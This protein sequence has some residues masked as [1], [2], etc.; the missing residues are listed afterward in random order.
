MDLFKKPSSKKRE[1][2]QLTPDLLSPKKEE[3]VETDRERGLEKGREKIERL[4]ERGSEQI[5]T[6][7]EDKPGLKPP[8]AKPS[9]TPA[10][11][12]V[13]LQKIENILQ[14]DLEKLYFDMD[15]AHRRLFKEEGERA[16][17]KIEKFLISCKSVAIKVL[18]IIK[19]WL[20]LIPGINK[21]FIEQEAK[22]KTDKIIKINR[23]D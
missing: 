7:R 16:A 14:E 21:F 3:E 12:S 5:Q 22:I 19:N 11:K 10:A 1:A 6:F 20:R 4:K 15:E 9:A 8:S 18:E 23:P 2:E 13:N 17:A